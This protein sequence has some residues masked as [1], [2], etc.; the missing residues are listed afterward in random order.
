MALK[1]GTQTATTNEARLT[2]TLDI[3]NVKNGILG[4]TE[5]FYNLQR[6]VGG[7]E[8]SL[9]DEEELRRVLSIREGVMEIA[10]VYSIAGKTGK[11]A[12]GN[13]EAAQKALG[14]TTVSQLVEKSAAYQAML[15]H[16][17]STVEQLDAAYKS[18]KRTFEATGI[19]VEN[20]ITPPKFQELFRAEND[21]A[22]QAE[23][24]RQYQIYVETLNKKAAARAEFEAQGA[25]QQQL[26]LA[27]QAA[28]EK[29]ANEAA[30]QAVQE[31]WAKERLAA[32]KT[33]DER[34]AYEKERAQEQQ[35]WIAENAEK[36]RLAAQKTRDARIAFEKEVGQ[37]RDLQTAESAAKEK[38]RIQGITETRDVELA[39][40]RGAAM[41]KVADQQQHL[42]EVQGAYQAKIEQ[43]I[44][45]ANRMNKAFDESAIAAK[46][47]ADGSGFLAGAWSR[48]PIIAQRVFDAMIVYK[49]FNL[50][51]QGIRGIA[52]AS[53]GMAVRLD[54]ARA[55]MEGLTGSVEQTNRVLRDS[56]KA[57]QES[58]ITF[59]E[60]AKNA[61]ILQARGLTPTIALLRTLAATSI[62]L[63]K[64]MEGVVDTFAKLTIR[65]E[66]MSRGLI[67]LGISHEEFLRSIAKGLSPEQAMEEA[68][69][70]NLRVMDEMKNTLPVLEKNLSTA[71]GV[72][73]IGTSTALLESWKD[74]IAEATRL[75]RDLNTSIDEYDVKRRS[76][77]RNAILDPQTNAIPGGQAS[78][79]IALANQQGLGR[80][81]AAAIKEVNDAIRANQ[82]IVA[83]E[84]ENA[85]S[86]SVA[87]EF[88]NAAN[89][90]EERVVKAVKEYQ[91]LLKRL[92]TGTLGQQGEIIEEE[93]Q[94][95]YFKTLELQAQIA[96]NEAIIANTDASR[97]AGLQAQVAAKNAMITAVQAEYDGIVKVD[98]AAGIDI[99]KAHDA[100]EAKKKLT[101]LE[102]ERQV[103]L[104][105]ITNEEAAQQKKAAAAQQ[106]KATAEARTEKANEHEFAMMDQIYL[107][108]AKLNG[109]LDDRDLKRKEIQ[110]VIDR[111]GQAYDDAVNFGK[112]LADQDTHQLAYL[113][114][115]IA[116]M[117]AERGFKRDDVQ[118]ANEELRISKELSNEA[119][120][121]TALI[122]QS[123]KFV[124]GGIQNE[125]DRR[126]EQAR[127]TRDDLL[128]KNNARAGG[129]NVEVYRNALIGF[130]NTVKRINQDE[131]ISEIS[132]SFAGLKGVLRGFSPVLYNI[133]ESL[134]KSYTAVNKDGKIGGMGAS[135]AT[136]VQMAEAAAVA[137]FFQGILEIFN[138][139]AAITA[140]Q[141]ELNQA[142]ATGI[143]LENQL[144]DLRSGAN[145]AVARAIQSVAD[146][147]ANL[148]QAK[149]EE[150]AVNLMLIAGT[151]DRLN[152]QT[153]AQKAQN[154][155]VQ[156]NID[157]VKAQAAATKEFNDGLISTI[158]MQQKF[159]GLS[160][161]QTLDN[162]SSIM[163]QF[164]DMP[165]AD[166]R[167]FGNKM[168][169]LQK[170]IIDAETAVKVKKLNDDTDLIIKNINDN[171]KLEQ[172]ARTA[173]N[174]VQKSLLET[175]L[176]GV[177]DIQNEELR[178]RFQG[179]FAGTMGNAR[180]QANIFADFSRQAEVLT[181][182]QQSRVAEESAKLAATLIAA[183]KAAA[184][185][186][187]GK[188]DAANAH[189]DEL[190]EA[191]NATAKDQ[192]TLFGEY[193]NAMLNL[194]LGRLGTVVPGSTVGGS[195]GGATVV[196]G[197]TGARNVT[198]IV[199]LP[200]GY[201][202]DPNVVVAHIT[203][204]L[205]SGE[206]DGPVEKVIA[207]AD[208]KY[209]GLSNVGRFQ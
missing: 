118:A 144:A 150:A 147:E 153:A 7:G 114:A 170:S 154:D 189:R 145:N 131:T 30:Y 73:T 50:V 40:A 85:L 66:G 31:K 16:N 79:V 18:L 103:L 64:P 171:A 32:Q 4:I 208:R 163:D 87:V 3:E 20:Q 121:R 72:G 61:S 180:A 110:M 207:R 15:E 169:D 33:I 93:K 201:S 188:I 22:I 203:N 133:G 75:I 9:F 156:A 92:P 27:E 78:S 56:I 105:G 141:K 159:R 148:V 39:N 183:D 11:E 195:T 182:A 151:V 36:E 158:E 132:K 120:E 13:I 24:Q 98:K 12:M 101:D 47:A 193:L 1:I 113:R 124:A 178:L 8:L 146:A 5:A 38:A 59:D 46:K 49:L 63:D 99:T 107:A 126:R 125:F 104:H 181:Q 84:L 14:A 100:L 138:G 97:L 26:Y 91:T 202:G 80:Q 157:L 106:K 117:E 165:L 70:K 57:S 187:Q 88:G 108:Q 2:A 152:A 186:V 161:Q 200:P 58:S 115:K 42:Q 51:E 62:A 25:Q 209:N 96:G 160:D 176:R 198:V 194:Q 143:Q 23:G 34:A 149:L 179:A 95:A 177:F 82:E 48:L 67:Q 37:Q 60:M 21:A 130:D 127:I 137:G 155:V 102:R 172:D 134:V 122:V 196:G 28:R 199:Q 205:T 142:T 29:A 69:R 128:E 19:P 173:A 129:W 197:T 206:L 184:D 175:M 94:K 174:D 6:E 112:S 185:L 43:L 52:D 65:T 190:L 45:V 53:L 164:K 111:E 54:V 166:R 83:N 116:L 109:L 55:R 77:Q 89:K 162:L 76:L 71:L 81:A 35:L 123:E 168:F 191:I 86:G 44:P 192:L 17:V 10:K 74:V 90:A 119:K 167:G 139:G 136:G 68:L 140:A 41:K 204:A 135:F